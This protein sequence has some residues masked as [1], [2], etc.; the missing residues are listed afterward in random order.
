MR[1]LLLHVMECIEECPQLNMALANLFGMI[2]D[3]QKQ[4]A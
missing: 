3:Y 2:S 1:E 4:A